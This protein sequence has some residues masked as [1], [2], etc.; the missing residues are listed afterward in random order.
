MWF[1]ENK[2]K[3][4]LFLMSVTACYSACFVLFCKQCTQV[5][6]KDTLTKQRVHKQTNK[7]H[8]TCRTTRRN[9]H[10]EQISC[11]CFTFFTF[12]IYLNDF[13]KKC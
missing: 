3:K 1:K 13:S 7:Q 4:G 10:S 11:A 2:T 6:F 5:K 9:R 8:E 12:Y